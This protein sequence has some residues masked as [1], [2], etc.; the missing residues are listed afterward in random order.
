MK[1][2]ILLLAFAFVGCT[3]NQN[4]KQA[5]STKQSEDEVINIVR[6]YH[7]A[8]R[9]IYDHAPLNLDS[10][11]DA[12]FDRDMYYVTYWGIT[13]PIDSTKARLRRALPLIKDSQNR[14]EEVTVKTYGQSAYLFFTLRQNYTLDGRQM[15]EYL[16]TTY[17]LE[18]RG[19]GWKIVHAH[20]SAD[21]QTIQQLMQAAQ[22]K[23]QHAKG[24][25]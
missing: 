15:E 4:D 2:F 14:F 23:E 9:M 11:M 20:R 8:L 22:F 17:I 25:P 12:Y 19:D 13:E 3:S 16:P 21:L 7:Q 10:L 1:P 6:N 18:R 24:K 5:A